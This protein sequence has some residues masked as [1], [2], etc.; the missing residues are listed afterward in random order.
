MFLLFS[1]INGKRFCEYERSN[2]M[3]YVRTE[4]KRLFFIFLIPMLIH[5]TYAVSFAD[6]DFQQW[7]LEF[8][9]T[10]QRQG[11]SAQT[12]DEAFV[13]VKSP[14]K[15]VLK[16]AN[17][18]PEFKTEIWDYLDARVNEI[19]V[20]QG[21]RMSVKYAPVLETVEERFGVSKNIILAI[22]S[23]ESAYGAVLKNKK[24]LH[25]VPLALATLA[26]GD[27]KRQKF[28]K[29]QLIAALKILQSG[30]IDYENMVGSWAGA[31]GH[32]QF[33]PTSYL[34]YGIDFDNDGRRDIWRS[35][36]D[37]LA[38][39]ANLLHK[40]GWQSG[41]TWGYE[42][43]LPAGGAQYEGMTKTLAEWENLGFS[44][45][46]SKQFPRKTDR[47]ECVL[48]AGSEGPAYL[49]LRNFFV[50]KKYNNANAYALAVGLLADSFAGHIGPQHAWPRPP[51]ALSGDEKF[52]LQRLL[53]KHGFYHG[54]IDGNLGSKSRE[55]VRRFQAA[56]GLEADGV[57]DKSILTLLRKL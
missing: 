41:K 45:I 7:L 33:I 10:A 43:D 25:Y 40:N 42:V 2:M 8:S 20:L 16:K 54:E 1:R 36:P 52:T 24:R 26:Y 31:M 57:P 38:T 21:L 47:A 5:I 46:Q 48:L 18:Q 30:D 22:W 17:Y 51:G 44:R 50:L 27:K 9:K 53:K 34:L 37:A 49:M 14:D 32:T 15:R 13:R 55:A 29:T 35:V 3:H 19:A 11:I 4:N 23:M 56:Y 6:T 28:A 39:A 12:W